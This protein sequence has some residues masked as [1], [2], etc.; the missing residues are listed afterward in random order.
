MT[1]GFIL[2]CNADQQVFALPENSASGSQKKLEL[3][4]TKHCIAPEPTYHSRL[5]PQTYGNE[6]PLTL[7]NTGTLLQC[8]HRPSLP[9]AC[10]SPVA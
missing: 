1:Q 7:H 2:Q 8:A 3:Q 10:L 6:N 4:A 5:I 9:E